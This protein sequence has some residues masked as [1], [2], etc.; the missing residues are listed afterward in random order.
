MRHRATDDE[1]EFTPD[2]AVKNLKKRVFSLIQPT[3][4]IHIGNYLGAIRYWVDAQP[5]FD[6]IFCIVDL[7]AITT[8]QD[9]EEFRVKIRETAGLLLAAGIG[10]SQSVLYLQSKYKVL[11]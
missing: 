8:P 6:N 7:H 9:P 11:M 5:V 4:K 3:G 10:P 2:T 1:P